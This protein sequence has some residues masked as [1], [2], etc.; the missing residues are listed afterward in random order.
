MTREVET[1]LKERSIQSGE[2][3]STDRHNLKKGINQAK[4]VYKEQIEDHFTN[5]DPRYSICGKV[6]TH[7]QLQG[8][9]GT[10]HK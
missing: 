8:E 4:A 5:I 2:Q 6:L 3:Y 9:Q 10:T 7:Y 1:I